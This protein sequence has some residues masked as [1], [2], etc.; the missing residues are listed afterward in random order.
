MKLRRWLVFSLALNAVL[1]GVVVWPGHTR[2]PDVGFGLVSRFITNRVVRVRHVIVETPPEVVEVT[3][4]FHWAEVEAS[5]YRV[6]IEN[7]RNLGC[8]ENR[9]HDIVVADVGELFAGRVRD[10]VAP[11]QSRFWELMTWKKEFD[12]LVDTKQKELRAL[13]QERDEVFEALFGESDRARA[14]QQR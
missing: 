8:P 5:D 4:P 2:G 10:L 7:L 6:F 12:E 13:S 14:R 3:A 11:V 9:V 1:A